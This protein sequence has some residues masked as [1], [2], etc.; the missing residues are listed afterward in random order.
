MADIKCGRCDRH[1]SK[2]RTRCPYCGAARNKKGKRAID[3]DNATWKV[4]AGSAIIVVLI[5]AVAAV[6]I[7]T[8]AGKNTPK[9]DNPDKDNQENVG[10]NVED[11]NGGNSDSSGVDSVDGENPDNEPEEEVEETGPVLNSIKITTRGGDERT[12][13]TMSVQSSVTLSYRTDPD[14]FE[15]TVTWSSS[16]ENVLVV[17]QTGELKAVATG[18][19]TLKVTLGDKSAECIV[20]VVE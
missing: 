10:S 17:L 5:A 3:R 4:V 8:L 14:D 1:Y 2:F 12:D 9:V 16:D 13:I 6:L 20:R 7:M 18:T 15:G 19:V 11:T